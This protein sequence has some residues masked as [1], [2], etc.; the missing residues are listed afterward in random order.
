[1]IGWN[2][3]SIQSSDS[4]IAIRIAAIEQAPPGASQ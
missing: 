1:V 4:A 2:R 3:H